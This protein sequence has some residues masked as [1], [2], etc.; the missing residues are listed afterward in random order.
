MRWLLA[1]PKVLFL[2]EPTRGI[3]VGAKEQI[4]ELMDEPAHRG[5][6]MILVSSEMSELLHCTYRVIILCEER[7]VGIV[8]ADSTSQEEILSM[9]TGVLAIASD[10][11]SH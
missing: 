6:V 3:D 2:G 1:E 5:T 9:G 10:Q 7:Q 11:S 4:Y 8:N